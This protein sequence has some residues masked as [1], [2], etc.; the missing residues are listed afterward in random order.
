MTNL[1]IV[2]PII[3]AL[4]I[5]NSVFAQKEINP[6]VD[7]IKMSGA[8]AAIG[9]FAII[10]LVIWLVFMVAMILG[11]IFWIFMI[12]DVAKRKFPN[13]SDKIMWILLVVL[14]G[15]IG[16]IVYYFVVKRA[17]KKQKV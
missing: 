1:K 5:L 9:G 10:F 2:I 7:P 4:L 8:A 14:L 12:I 15:V 16:A 17:D 11:I 6:T 3:L 13:D